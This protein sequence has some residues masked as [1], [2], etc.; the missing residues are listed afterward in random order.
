MVALMFWQ[1]GFTFYA[2][3]VVPIG[4]DVLGSPAAQGWITRRVTGYLNLA[5]AVALVVLGWDV[6]ASRDPRRWRRLLRWLT[7]LVMATAL[8]VLVWLHPR[9]DALLDVDFQEILDRRLFRGLHRRY[10][11]VSTAQ[12]AAGI[13]AVLLMLRAWQGEDSEQ[14]RD[15][16]VKKR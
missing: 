13:A 16:P 6:A 3:V 12:W 5:G 1:G 14:R 10:L 7:W 15:L 8:G 9:L 11:W 2:A 4:T